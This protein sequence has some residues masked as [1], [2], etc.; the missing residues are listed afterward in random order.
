MS[1]VEYY[2]QEF[3]KDLINLMN[4]HEFAKERISIVSLVDDMSAP[5]HYGVVRDEFNRIQKQQFFLFSFFFSVLIDQSIY[6][7]ARHLHQDFQN[8]A[9]YPKLVGI[10]SSYWSNLH[11]SLLLIASIKHTENLENLKYDFRDLAK[12]LLNDYKIF[13]INNFQTILNYYIQKK[14]SK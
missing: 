11:P 6:S 5:D 10:L 13:F 7:V 1:I 2:Q 14:K 3:S 12:Y 4:S 8:I 9:Q